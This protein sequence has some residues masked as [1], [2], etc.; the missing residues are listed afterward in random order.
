MSE[1]VPVSVYTAPWCAYCHAAREYLTVKKVKFKEIDVSIDQEA[2]HRLV[3]KTGMSA[4]PVI[5]IGEET[6][7][8]FD[9]EKIDGALREHKLV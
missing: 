2:A 5:E 6:I 4:V 7:I 1:T 3:M 8:G 9:R